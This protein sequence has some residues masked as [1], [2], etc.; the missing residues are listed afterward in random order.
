MI[1]VLCIILLCIIVLCI[2]VLCIR[3]VL[4]KNQLNKWMIFHFCF[5][6]L[7]FSFVKFHVL[8]IESVADSF[9]LCSSYSYTT[10][11]YSSHKPR[12]GSQKH[13]HFSNR[14]YMDRKEYYPLKLPHRKWEREKEKS[15]YQSRGSPG[16]RSAPKPS[17][18]TLCLVL[19]ISLFSTLMSTS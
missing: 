4:M 5:C 3:K 9:P 2:I 18:G 10:R 7:L 11:G 8:M 17:S 12:A 13:H 15:W 6:S 19:M 16:P 1:I 14:E